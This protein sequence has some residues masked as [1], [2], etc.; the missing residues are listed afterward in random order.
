MKLS[1]IILKEE[2]GVAKRKLQDML[3]QTDADF[4]IDK[5]MS[6]EDENVLDTLVDA[7]E[8]PRTFRSENRYNEDGYDEGDIKLMGDMILPTGKMVVLQA[9]EN[10]Y[11]RGLLVTSNEDRSYD[12]AYWADD[13]TKPYPIGIEI[14]GKEV[15]KDANIIKFLFHPEMK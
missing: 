9:E 1:D 10:K 3:Q 13:K 5:I 4:I 2:L 12:V 6:I 15:A 11:N 7:L 8:A 14:D